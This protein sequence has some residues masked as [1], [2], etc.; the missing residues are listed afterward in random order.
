MERKVN[1][2]RKINYYRLVLVIVAAVLIVALPVCTVFIL[3]RGHVINIHPDMKV[4]SET[5]DSER[6]HGILIDDISKLSPEGKKLLEDYFNSSNF[7]EEDLP[8]FFESFL[9]QYPASTETDRKE[10]NPSNVTKRLIEVSYQEQ[11]LYYYENDELIFTSDV[12]TGNETTEIIPYGTYHVLHMTTDATL[13]GADYEKHVDYWIGF[14]NE[15]GGHMVGFHDASWRTVFGG[16][17][18]RTNPT[19]ECI[20]MPTDKVKQLYEAVNVGTEIHIHE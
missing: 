10:T 1:K 6:I 7:N 18:W 20:N 11:K 14:D 5:K 13:V 8:G 12:V 16:D 4:G 19:L 3:E 17:E 9:E 2:K 15:T